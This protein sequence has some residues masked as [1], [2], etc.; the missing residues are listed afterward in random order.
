MQ[1]RII[2]AVITMLIATIATAQRRFTVAQLSYEADIYQTRFSRVQF[3]SNIPLK[4]TPK[5]IWL[6]SPSA[7]VLSIPYTRETSGG[8]ALPLTYVG[9]L[10]KKWSFQLSFI[11]RMN[12]LEF[13]PENLQLGAS[14]LATVRLSDSLSLKFG[15]YYN[16]EYF[17]GFFVPLAG[18]DYRINSKTYLY[19]TLPGSLTIE[20]AYNETFRA[21]I[22]FRS[23]TGSYMNGDTY[24]LPDRRYFIRVSESKLLFFLEK[25]LLKH[26]SAQAEL[27]H[28]ITRRFTYYDYDTSG[29]FEYKQ[30]HP[31]FNLSL[32]YRITPQRR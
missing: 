1:A 19:G 15:L 10:D 29:D 6:I 28:S 18:I 20:K 4:R 3:N 17:G 14:G 12:D 22:S 7:E 2:L 5:Q 23:F 31:F 13:R 30:L 24:P 8:V 11:P 25:S 16:S 9:P 21:G 26:L 27:G 32:A